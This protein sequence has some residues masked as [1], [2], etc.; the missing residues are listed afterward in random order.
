M[1]A[2]RAPVPFT[3]SSAAKGA[4]G[5]LLDAILTALRPWLVAPSQP[6]P[7][8]PRV[9]V[10][11]PDHLGDAV[12]ATSVLT[13]LADA[14]TPARLD[15]LCAPWSVDVFA[16]HR[17]V[18]QAIPVRLPWWLAARGAS[19]GSRVAAWLGLP[20]V[21][22]MV[23]RRRYDVVLE[24]RGDLR[25]ILCFG[26]LSGAPERIGTDRTGGRA[27][28]TRCWPFDGS[29]HEVEKAMGIVATLGVRRA[30][31]PTLTPPAATTPEVEAALALAAGNGRQ[32]LVLAPWGSQPA[33][34]CSEAQIAAIARHAAARGLGL[35][36]VG[37][38][39]D[40]P[41]AAAICRHLGDAEA[42]VAD[43][44][45]RTTVNDLTWVMARASAAICVDSGPAHVAA[46]VGTPVAVVFGPTD[47]GQ[48]RPW[49]GE[50]TVLTTDPPGTPVET[51]EPDRLCRM[52]AE[53]LG[54]ALRD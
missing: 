4:A 5:R 30:G 10:V 39:A 43:L 14:L 24:L 13:P 31:R 51:L 27:L 17:A 7:A 16:Q 37:A 35:A 11:R 20:A 29:L 36:L 12:L 19:F 32:W 25:Q 33:K 26:A 8:A 46:A 23:R 38:A 9:L 52:I 6:L 53:A 3:P 49:G 34:S 42:G 22:A 1:T 54:G 18:T 47:P 28:L 21:I 50:V 41:R 40:R 45:G 15:V 2:G 44:T 48:F